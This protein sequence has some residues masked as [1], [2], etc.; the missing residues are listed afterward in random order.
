MKA[1]VAGLLLAFATVAS[2]NDAC[3]S[4]HPGGQVPVLT[5]Q[6]LAP[7]TRYLCFED[8]AVL[9]SGITH[10]P[11]WS[12][13]HLTR[14]SLAS[15][16]GLTRTNRFYEEPSLPAG[17]GATLADYRHAPD[18][19]RGHMSPAGDRKDEQAMSSSFTLANIV[20]QESNLNRHLWSRIE[21][22]VRYLAKKTG[23]AYVI[24]GPLFIGKQ[25][26]TI[27]ANRVFIPTQ[28]FKVVYL[29]SQQLS[30]AVVVDNVDTD[31]YSV[32]TVHELE[33]MSGISFPGIPESA[34]FKTIGGLKGV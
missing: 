31:T 11:L 2:A 4:I 19:D 16:K 15:A 14:D 5:N 28:I 22:Q 20:P 9:H 30:F 25:L 7:K 3:T 24:T 12:A 26:Q 21:S 33:A 32:K 10:T 13:E 29:P 8:F 17:E 6:K 27:G 23:E 18:I 1:F 34:K